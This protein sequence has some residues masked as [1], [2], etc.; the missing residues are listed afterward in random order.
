MIPFYDYSVD[1]HENMKRAYEQGVKDMRL[2]IYTEISKVADT[3]K[4]FNLLLMVRDMEI[5]S[6]EF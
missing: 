3:E 2:K 4:D 5:Q 1:C 6:I